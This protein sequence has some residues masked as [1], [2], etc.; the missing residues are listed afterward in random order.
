MRRKKKKEEKMLKSWILCFIMVV[1]D[2]GKHPIFG[3]QYL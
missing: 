3:T 1:N 2:I